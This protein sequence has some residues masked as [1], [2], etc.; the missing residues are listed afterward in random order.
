MLKSVRNGLFGLLL[1]AST[2]LASVIVVADRYGA[3]DGKNGFYPGIHFKIDKVYD[4]NKKQEE[5]NSGIPV[6]IY[7]RQENLVCKTISNEKGFGECRLP[8]FGLYSVF[9]NNTDS[10][11]YKSKYP[12]LS[13]VVEITLEKNWAY[14]VA[15]L[16]TG[17]EIYK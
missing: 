15:A 13:T 11:N 12:T 4:C 16:D 3:V 2:A 7:D 1:S 9:V 6:T 10:V 14:I 5:P 8:R 17:C